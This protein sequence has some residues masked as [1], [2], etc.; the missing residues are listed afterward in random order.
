[1]GFFEGMQPVPCFAGLRNLVAVSAQ[2]GAEGLPMMLTIGVGEGLG[3]AF[4]DTNF[5]CAAGA[6]VGLR[7]AS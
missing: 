6:P 1:M 5:P 3:I 2:H 7:S 4:V